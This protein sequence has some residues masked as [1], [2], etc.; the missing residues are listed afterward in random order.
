VLELG[1]ELRRDTGL[2]VVS[3][4]H[5]LSLAGQYADRLVLLDCGTVAAEGAAPEVLSATLVAAHYGADV[6]VL[7]DDGAVFVVPRRRVRL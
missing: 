5:D 2:T 1:D 4:M 3:A 7:H 6:R